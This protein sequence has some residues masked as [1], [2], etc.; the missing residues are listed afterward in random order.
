MN[1][2]LWWIGMVVL[3]IGYYCLFFDVGHEYSKFQV[4]CGWSGV[5]FVSWLIGAYSD[6]KCSRQLDWTHEGIACLLFSG[7]GP[8]ALGW[9]VYP[10]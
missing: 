6:W 10:D 4:F 3:L 2:I 7:L 8:I 1:R 9:S 5:G